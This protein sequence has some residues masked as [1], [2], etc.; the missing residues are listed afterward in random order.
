VK[1]PLEFLAGALRA[2]G[3][4]PDTTPRLAVMLQ[5]LGQPLFLM[6]VPTGWPETMADWVN[7]GALLT[8]MNMAVGLASG[9]APGVIVH[10]DSVVPAELDAPELIRRVNALIL[11]GQATPNT[12]RVLEQQVSEVRDP[13]AAR[14]LAIGLALGSPEFQRQ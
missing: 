3:A 13:V 2:V 14:S 7:S 4:V 8:R 6:Q 11:A 10:L 1:S 9:R 12:L 5:Q